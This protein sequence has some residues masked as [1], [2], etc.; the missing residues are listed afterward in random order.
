MIDWLK[1]FIDNYTE[2]MYLPNVQIKDVVEI[3]KYHHEKFDG[4]GYPYG[5]RGEEIPLGSR[6][7]AVADAFDSI[8]SS[9][10][11]RS[12]VNMDEA[13]Q[14]IKEGAGT[15]FDP[16]VIKAFEESFEEIV[17]TA[18]EDMVSDNP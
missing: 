8:I 4:T 3:I 5:I 2:G 10:V 15:Q 7:I 13:L 14:K 1:N 17:K 11:Y 9:R 6:I 12:A 16:V 18:S